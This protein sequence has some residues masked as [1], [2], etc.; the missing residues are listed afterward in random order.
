MYLNLNTVGNGDFLAF[1]HCRPKNEVFLLGYL[2]FVVGTGAFCFFSA[3]ANG[4]IRYET[5]HTPFLFASAMGDF[6]LFRHHRRH[7]QVF[8]SAV[9]K[10]PLPPIKAKCLRARLIP[11][12]FQTPKPPPPRVVGKLSWLRHVLQVFQLGTPSFSVGKGDFGL[13]RHCQRDTPD[14]SCGIGEFWWHIGFRT[15]SGAVSF[16]LLGFRLILGQASARGR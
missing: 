2:H 8:P 13:P 14:F 11:D 5:G 10:T 3:I 9:A 1:C 15:Q 16:G 12:T 4:T 7:D 6:R